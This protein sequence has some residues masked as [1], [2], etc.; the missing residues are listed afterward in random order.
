MKSKTTAYLLWFFSIFG[1][2]GFQHFYLGKIGK[3][4]IWILTGGVFG[5]GSLIDLFTLG[6]AVDNYNTKEEL[7]TIRASAMRNSTK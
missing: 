2:L 4:I 5:I 7:K 1:W 3:G 6:G